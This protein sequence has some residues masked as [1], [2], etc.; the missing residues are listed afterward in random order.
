[1]DDHKLLE[2]YRKKRSVDGFNYRLWDALKHRQYEKVIDVEEERRRLS[3]QSN[4]AANGVGTCHR[5]HRNAK[6]C[7]CELPLRAEPPSPN[8]PNPIGAKMI[9]LI[10]IQT[11]PGVWKIT[12]SDMVDKYERPDKLIKKIR[13]SGREWV[14]D[15]KKESESE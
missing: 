14:E 12:T 9:H 13:E 6:Q 8:P 1:M 10:A 7:I 11:S 15:I 3:N 4:K 5:C 2:L